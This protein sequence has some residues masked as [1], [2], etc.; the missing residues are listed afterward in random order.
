MDLHISLI[1]RRNLSREI[2][3]Q[4]RSAIMDGRLA[5]RQPLPA[6]RELARRLGVARNTVTVAYDRLAGE[7]FVT[8]R[9]GSGTFVSSQVADLRPRA[10]AQRTYGGVRGTLQPRPVWDAVALP[11]AFER[12]AEFDFRAG[13]PDATLFPY[14]EWRRLTALALRAES[15]TRVVYGHPQG[16]PAL[17][18]AIARHIALSRGVVTLMDDLTVTNGTQQALDLVARAILEPGDVVAVEEPCYPPA[19]RLFESLGL[20][21]VAVPVDRE[22][23]VADALPRRARLVYVTPSHQFPLGVAMSLPRRLALLAW[24]DR[25]GVAVVEDDYDSEFRL[26]DRPIEPLHLLDSAGRVIYVGSYSKTLLPTL[27]LG[28]VVT[29]PSLTVAVQKAKYV[30]DWHTPHLSQ[31][32]LATFLDDGGFA[33]HIRKMQRVYEARHEIIT[34]VLTNELAGHL[35]LIPSSVGLHVAALARTL[36]VERLTAVVRRAAENGVEVHEMAKVSISTPP[37]AGLVIGYGAIPTPRIREGL[38]RIR[39]AFDH[40]GS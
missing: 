21:I 33:R 34:H 24:A 4:L 11:T 7:G 18:A 30:S 23:L 17:R 36:S 16:D 6:T 28:F 9:V 10:G 1:G 37:R 2:Y 38:R 35:E 27:R 31:A 3:Q 25:N 19:R 40:T 14:D 12:T 5:P 32:A 13:L 39:T 20:R 26:H 29:P 8:S 22:G 15:G